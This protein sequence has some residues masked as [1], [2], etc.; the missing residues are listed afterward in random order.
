MFA[1]FSLESLGPDISTAQV[2]IVAKHRLTCKYSAPYKITDSKGDQIWRNVEFKLV[3]KAETYIYSVPTRFGPSDILKILSARELRLRRQSRPVGTRICNTWI[4]LPA[5]A[6]CQRAHRNANTHSSPLL[7]VA[8]ENRLHTPVEPQ[9]EYLYHRPQIPR[10]TGVK[11]IR[12][13]V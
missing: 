3:T 10:N 8:N 2:V 9:R 7:I 12:R 6:I 4:S 13:T 11:W 1:I 5:D